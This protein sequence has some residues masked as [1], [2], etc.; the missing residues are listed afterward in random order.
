[1]RINEVT[2]SSSK[3]V[4]VLRTVISSA[5]RKGT[6]LFLHFTKPKEENIKQG[7][8]N[9]DLNKLMQNEATRSAF[10]INVKIKNKINRTK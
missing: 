2:D 8:K 1:M 9:L 5:D 10:R 4:Q 3:L 7:A 6:P